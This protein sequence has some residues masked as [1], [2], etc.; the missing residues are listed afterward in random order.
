MKSACFI[1]CHVFILFFY[2]FL[3]TLFLSHFNFKKLCHYTLVSGT[4]GAS[5]LYRLVSQLWVSYKGDRGNWR[6]GGLYR[7]SLGLL[8]L[9]LLFLLSVQCAP[10]HIRNTEHAAAFTSKLRKLGTGSISVFSAAQMM[11]G[12]ID[13]FRSYFIIGNSTKSTTAGRSCRS[14]LSM[15]DRNQDLK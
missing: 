9:S 4:C 10:V 1:Y 2:I 6:C 7:G 3:Y 5:A 12:R 15:L 11:L 14:I 13:T 8:L